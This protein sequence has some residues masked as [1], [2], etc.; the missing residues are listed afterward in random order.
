MN[1]PSKEI[2]EALYK[3]ALKHNVPLTMLEALAFDASGFDAAKKLEQAGKATRFGLFGFTDIQLE[4]YGVVDP[5]N[6][7]QAIE[8]ACYALRDIFK[9]LPDPAMAFAAWHLG[10]VTAVA[11][12]DGT[13]PDTWPADVRRAVQ[14]LMHIR[15]WFQDRGMPRGSDRLEHLKNAI[16]ALADLNPG[17]Q[18]R[19]NAAREAL[20][21]YEDTYCP[22]RFSMACKSCGWRIA[23]PSTSYRS[24]RKRRPFR[25]ASSRIGGARPTTRYSQAFRSSERRWRRQQR[26]LAR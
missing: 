26:R 25:S 5:F 10:N 7:A 13:T 21:A 9:H 22:T 24:P 11:H 16:Q 4:A 14:K 3:A 15:Y 19:I 12:L 8:G 17:L 1:T 23:K 6:A 2:Y 18:P 20:A